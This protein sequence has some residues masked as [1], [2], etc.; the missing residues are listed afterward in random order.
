MHIPVQLD[1]KM[2][3]ALPRFTPGKRVRRAPGQLQ[4][5]HRSSGREKEFL[6]FATLGALS[7]T[8]VDHTGVCRH[9]AEM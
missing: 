1:Y 3:V 4:R 6:R 7:A 2:F 9:M 5:R 8:S